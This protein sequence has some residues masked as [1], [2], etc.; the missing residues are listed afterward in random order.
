MSELINALGLDWKMLVAQLV[1]FGI[2]VAVLY[3]FAYKPLLK[4]LQKRSQMIADS[5]DKTEK[6]D[7]LLA[8]TKE[9]YKTKLAAAQEQSQEI[10]A[11]SKQEAEK[12]R[13]ES[14]AKTQEQM[15]AMVAQSRAAL[16]SEKDLLLDDIKKDVAD[17]VV[18]TSKKV[19]GREIKP[20]DNDKLIAE[21]IA[22]IKK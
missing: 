7:K 3:F 11:K 12:Y 6:I 5:L 1:N 16:Q 15:E 17:L 20:A 13:L 14:I 9:D 2:L 21:T 4:V 22:Q 18:A 8:K 19:I 10:L